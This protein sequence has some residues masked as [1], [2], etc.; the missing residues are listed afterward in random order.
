MRMNYDHRRW[1]GWGMGVQCSGQVYR[2]LC[3]HNTMIQFPVSR[4]FSSCSAVE[5]AV[6][7]IDFA[8]EV[9]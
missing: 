1:D 8:E 4:H 3:E 2:M 6:V 9:P 7:L 5:S